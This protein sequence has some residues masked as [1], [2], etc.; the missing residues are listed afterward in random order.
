MCKNFEDTVAWTA[1]PV[2][3]ADILTMPPLPRSCL[4]FI[5]S[6]V[7]CFSIWI[8]S[9]QC[10]LNNF[11]SLATIEV[12]YSWWTPPWASR[13]CLHSGLDEDFLLW[14][15]RWLLILLCKDVLVIPM[16][17][18]VESLSISVI[19]F[20]QFILYTTPMV[21]QGYFCSTIQFVSPYIQPF[22]LKGSDVVNPL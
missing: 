10:N 3:V 17:L 6:G 14:P 7:G 21:S 13:S 8:A 1:Y 5:E 11:Y 18:S 22:N 16:Y 20:L 12:E 19:Q 15:A 2:L 9:R 4:A